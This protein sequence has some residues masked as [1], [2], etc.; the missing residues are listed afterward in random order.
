M[1]LID[2]PSGAG[3]STL[4]DALVAGWP[5]TEHPQLVRLDDIYPGWNGL[6]AAA[7]H[8]TERVLRPRRNGDPAAWRRYDWS[9]GQPAEW[10]PVWPNRPLLVEGCGTLAAANAGLSDVRLW[11]DA[12]DRVRK[13]RALARDGETFGAH[14]DQWQ[15]EWAAYCIRETP[16]RWATIRL[17]SAKP[18]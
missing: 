14:W 8:L 11:L 18:G 10:N 2:G 15:D 16:E 6:D 13:A 5:N 7:A 3:K 17:F 12:D 1:V 4:A 9:A